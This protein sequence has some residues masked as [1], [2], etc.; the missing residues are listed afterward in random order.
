MSYFLHTASPAFTLNNHDSDDDG[1]ASSLEKPASSHFI[2][3]ALFS[4]LSTLRAPLHTFLCCAQHYFGSPCHPSHQ[5]SSKL[6]QHKCHPLILCVG[7]SCNCHRGCGLNVLLHG[8]RSEGN[9][10]LLG[11]VSC[12]RS[13]NVP[14]LTNNYRCLWEDFATVFV[15]P[16][17]I[18][19]RICESPHPTPLTFTHYLRSNP[20]SPHP[21]SS[22]QV[23]LSTLKT[24]IFENYVA[25][26]RLDGKPVQLALWDTACV[27]NY[28]WMTK[29][30]DPTSPPVARRNTR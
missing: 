22:R 29:V 9:L 16:W 13:L 14:C 11:T 17:R 19:K 18:P 10:S 24:A 20:V 6:A 23:V 8:L 3:R 5:T 4:F 25:E 26:I 2:L 7:H 1:V 21:V 15:C 30:A 12:L 28:H 27:P